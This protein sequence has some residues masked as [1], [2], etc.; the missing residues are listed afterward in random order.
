VRNVLGNTAATLA[1]R[2]GHSGIESMLR[3]ASDSYFFEQAQPKLRAV[4]G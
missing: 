4:R 1:V 3:E 2:N